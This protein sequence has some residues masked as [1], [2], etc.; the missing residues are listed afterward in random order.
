M[1][2]PSLVQ[3]CLGILHT[4]GVCAI[5][6]LWE[7]AVTSAYEKLVSQPIIHPVSHSVS[8]YQ[9]VTDRW[10]HSKVYPL[11][12]LSSCLL[13]LE[14]CYSIPQ[15]KQKIWHTPV[16]L[17]QGLPSYVTGAGQQG[18]DRERGHRHSLKSMCCSCRE[19]GLNSQPPHGSLQ[20]SVTPVPEHLSLSSAPQVPGMH[21]VYMHTVGKAFVK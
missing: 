12:V 17:T 11:H 3:H 6:H 19:A 9:C 16:Q 2:D 10:E 21:M 14:Y 5:C 13:I 15:T 18:A 8:L 4:C 1:S 7:G 20:P